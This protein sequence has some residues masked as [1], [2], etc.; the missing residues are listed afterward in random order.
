MVP[1]FSKR[2]PEN[3]SEFDILVMTNF[4]L[5][6]AIDTRIYTL[7]SGPHVTQFLAVVAKN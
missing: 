6:I 4:F 2:S 3:V 1:Y 5:H 7:S